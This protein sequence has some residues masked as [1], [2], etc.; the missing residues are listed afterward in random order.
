MNKYSDTTLVNTASFENLPVES[1]NKITWRGG[2]EKLSPLLPTDPGAYLGEFRSMVKTTGTPERPSVTFP[3]LPWNIVTRR[4]GRETYQRYSATEMLF[5]PIVARAR[6]VKYER[7]DG[8]RVKNDN[9]RNKIIATSAIFPGKGSGFDPH[10]EVFGY[11]LDAAGKIATHAL[12][13]LDSWNAYISY[14]NAAKQFESVRVEDGKLVVLKIGT[15]G[16]VVNG[17]TLPKAKS[18]NGRSFVEIEPLD[19]NSPRFF[20]I[21]QEFDEIWEAA[22]AWANCERWNASEIIHEQEL[23]PMQEADEL[24]AEDEHPF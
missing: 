14:N 1:F 3:V 9:G 12:L 21:T 8:F 23:P 7:A 22:Q 16:E 10:K 2:D 5:R 11:V 6:F 15:R 18:F 24:P 4:S 20:D 17:E 19:L 13:V